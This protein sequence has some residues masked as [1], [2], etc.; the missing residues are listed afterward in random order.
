MI[1]LFSKLSFFY[2]TDR[3]H[4]SLWQETKS[5]QEPYNDCPF[6]FIFFNCCASFQIIFSYRASVS[7][8]RFTVGDPHAVT[9][10]A[11]S[12]VRGQALRQKPEITGH[13]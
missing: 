10:L 7:L 8:E 11:R 2:V 12:A 3:N 13:S 6:G 4:Y 1:W 5:W 9:A